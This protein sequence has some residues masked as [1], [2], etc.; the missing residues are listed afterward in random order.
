MKTRHWTLGAAVLAG[1][2]ALAA[3]LLRPGGLT[4]R[5][6]DRCFLFV[7]TQGDHPYAVEVRVDGSKLAVFRNARPGGTETHRVVFRRGERNRFGFRLVTGAG[8]VLFEPQFT[9]AVPPG[10]MLSLSTRPAELAHDD[11]AG[12]P[13]AGWGPVPNAFFPCLDANSPY[14][15]VACWFRP[16]N[17]REDAFYVDLKDAA[18]LD[19]FEARARRAGYRVTRR[20]AQAHKA[21]HVSQPRGI[22]P[23]DAMLAVEAW[24]GVA[25]TRTV[26]AF[27]Y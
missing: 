9:R 14:R 19:G 7:H 23:V 15:Q 4:Y 24:P 12:R 10:G 22:T 17:A 20:K 13:Q 27:L 5:P 16:A 11:P 25:C 3:A 6:S 1:A 26:P 2:V 8:A 21:L 18:C